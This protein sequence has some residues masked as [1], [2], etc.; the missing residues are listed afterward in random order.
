MTQVGEWLKDI[1]MA[2]VLAGFL[3]MLLPNNEL[4]SVTKMIMGLVILLILLHPLIK[5]LDLPQKI[6]WSI[7]SISKTE[8]NPATREVIEHGMKMRE[9]WTKDIKEQNKSLLEGKL[10][11]IIELIGEAQMEEIKL[12]YKGYYPFRAV[13]KLKSLK[14]DS[15][16][17]TAK[18]V[19]ARNNIKHQVSSAVQLLTNLK[20]DQI[21][22]NWDGGE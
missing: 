19:I 9:N 11:N 3:E 15:T 14:R 4:K 13:I 1:I 2:I 21:E 8:S 6:S 22:V 7:A 5:F 12:E 17:V 20:E 16:G 10:K 18:E